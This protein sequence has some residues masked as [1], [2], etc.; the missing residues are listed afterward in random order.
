[1]AVSMSMGTIPLTTYGQY[2]P[3]RMSREAEKRNQRTA[4]SLLLCIRFEDA[5]VCQTTAVTWPYVH[6][7]FV[8]GGADHACATTE[9]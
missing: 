2:V 5:S 3:L 4:F 9:R 7:M 6:N 8:P 1:M